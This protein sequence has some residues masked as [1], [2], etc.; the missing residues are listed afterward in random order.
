[1]NLLIAY[2][3]TDGMTAQIAE[4]LGKVAGFLGHRTMV[5]NI[6]RLPTWFQ[7]QT[8][9][10][11]LVGASVH[12][13]G[14]QRSAKR[15]IRDN[16]ELLN[17]RPSAFFSVCMAIASKDKHSREEAHS[18]AE[19]FPAALGWKPQ[20]IEVIAGAIMFSRYGIFRRPVMRAIAR[21]EVGELDTSH[22]HIYTD[23]NAVEGFCRSFLEAAAPRL[24]TTM[25]IAR[26][27][28]SATTV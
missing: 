19:A 5:V 18:I 7:P 4:R 21:K 24:V 25:P 8:F 27:K 3:T 1:M 15:F 20:A 13:R 23:W 11:I 28:T 12:V 10:A 26:T 6:D 17:S 14:Y 22:D 16:L 2:A 9:D